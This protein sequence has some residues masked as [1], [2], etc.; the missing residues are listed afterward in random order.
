M[1]GYW[2]LLI[3][4]FMSGLQTYFFPQQMC[5]SSSWLE[6]WQLPQVMVRT[7]TWSRTDWEAQILDLP[8]ISCISPP[9]E[10]GNSNTY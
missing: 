3:T 10:K 8:F 5:L 2:E 1:L 6:I 4:Q 9:G 7:Q